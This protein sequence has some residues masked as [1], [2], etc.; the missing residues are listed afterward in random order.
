LFEVEP[1]SGEWLQIGNEFAI[2]SNGLPPYYR[3]QV[4]AA[5]QQRL[6]GMGPHQLVLLAA[7]MRHFQHR[8][9][10]PK[11]DVDE[12]GAQL[13]SP[14]LP[15]IT[16]R[17]LYE[18][19]FRRARS[20]N[21]DLALRHIDMA[22]ANLAQWTEAVPDSASDAYAWEVEKV[23]DKRAIRAD[24]LADDTLAAKALEKSVP[25]A[26]TYKLFVGGAQLGPFSR[27]EIA[28]R[29][30]RGEVDAATR[31]WNMQWNPKADKW[32]PLGEIAELAGLFDMIP[33]PDDGIPDPE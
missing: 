8:V 17:R 22:A 13:P 28:V 11:L 14:S 21:P 7:L 20:M 18:E 5:V 16:A 1:G 26:S 10:E 31:A 29:A 24:F 25:L 15:N 23:V 12:T 2:R 4:I 3:E 32:K 30:A 9:Y 27:D 19:W 33:D 6:A